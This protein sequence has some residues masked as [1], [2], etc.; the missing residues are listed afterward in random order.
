MFAQIGIFHNYFKDRGTPII[1]SDYGLYEVTK[2]ES[3]RYVFKIPSL[4]N[5]AITAPYMHDGSINTLPQAVYM[6][7][8][9]ELGI[10]IPPKDVETIVM[11]L[12]TLTG[13]T[14]EPKK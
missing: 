12:N 13:K 11:F 14:L 1:S 10:K 2:K 5:V 8:Y 4:R 3:D 6:M 9:Y 7:G